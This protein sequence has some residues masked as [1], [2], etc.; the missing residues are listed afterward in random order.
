MVEKIK[1]FF[2]DRKVR[3]REQR[4]NALLVE[5]EDRFDVTV[6]NDQLWFVYDSHLVCPMS[7]LCGVDNSN[8]V[9]AIGIMR[10]LYIKR[11]SGEW[12]DD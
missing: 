4:V 9:V 11:K 10:D 5:A 1:E 3:N 7:M 8:P 6:Y 12:N 2:H